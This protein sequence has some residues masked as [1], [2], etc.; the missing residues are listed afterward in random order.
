MEVELTRHNVLSRGYTPRTSSYF[1]FRL[2]SL[3]NLLALPPTA[4]EEKGAPFSPEVD[5]GILNQ[6]HLTVF[7]SRVLRLQPTEGPR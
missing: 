6:P 2:I 1:V 4:P 5:A 3:L 7:N